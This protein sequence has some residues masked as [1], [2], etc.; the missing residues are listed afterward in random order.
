MF[1]TEKHSYFLYQCRSYFNWNLQ[2]ILA[3]RL[4]FLIDLIPRV[5]LRYR[6]WKHDVIDFTYLLAVQYQVFPWLRKQ[7]FGLLGSIQL[8][9]T[10]M[11]ELPI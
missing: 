2:D 7:R 1:E 4:E 10:Q 8:N 5:T 9:G 3:V 11:E 6:Y